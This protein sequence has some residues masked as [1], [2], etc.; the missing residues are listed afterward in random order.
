MKR[1]I[2][3]TA[4]VSAA[5]VTS[6]DEKQDVTII[7]GGIVGFVIYFLFVC[8]VF[9]FG[10]I[11]YGRT[12]LAYYLSKSPKPINVSLIEKHHVGFGATSLSAG[13]VWAV[14]YGRKWTILPILP[15]FCMDSMN[16]YKEIQSSGH[17]IELIQNGNFNIAMTWKESW[18]IWIQHIKMKI[19]GYNVQWKWY[20]QIKKM[21]PNISDKVYCATFAPLSGHIN[22][23]KTAVTLAK[24]SQNNGVNIIENNGVSNITREDGIY[25]VHLDDGSKIYSKHIV[26]ANGAW[27]NKTG[28][29]LGINI[30]VF[31]VKG[32][33][34]VTSPVEQGTLNHVIYIEKSHTYFKEYGSRDD[35]HN[36]PQNCTH[37]YNGD[38]LVHH[39]YGRQLPNGQILFGG[40]RM[41]CELDDYSLDN[42]DILSNNKF[43]SDNILPI[44]ANIPIESKWAG[45]MPFSK[46]GNPIIGE[47]NNIGLNNCWLLCGFGPHGM[48]E[49]PGASKWISNKILHSL[50]ITD[51]N[52]DS[53]NT[54]DIDPL[55]RDGVTL[56]S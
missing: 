34:W 48:M 10:N 36:I 4:V 39:A 9:I 52:T 30:P 31:P 41:K 21:E 29:C 3:S 37:N 17:D 25:I 11:I 19:A 14:D 22:P 5:A 26:I 1:F 54:T 56:V 43:V 38:L 20:Y 46:D 16:L 7:G 50:G 2:K 45:I 18:N 51:M 28:T 49:G 47:L 55:R 42:D 32:Q 44:V 40:S 35:E 8:Y 24:I 53:Y 6:F 23:G 15:T 33:I 12:S 13:T 27:A